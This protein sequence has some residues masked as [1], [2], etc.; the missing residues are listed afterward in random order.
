M[1]PNEFPLH[2]LK[3]KVNCSIIL[4][5]N[6]NPSE[7]LCNGTRLICRRFDRSVIDAEISVGEHKGK[8]VLLPRI[9]FVPVQN[10][11]DVFHFKRKQ[12]PV[13]LCFA[14]TINKA[15]GQTLSYVG[16]YFR[17]PVF[18]HGQLYVVLSR[19]KTGDSVRVLNC[20]DLINKGDCRLTKNIIFEEL[21]SLVNC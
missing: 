9:P 5:R 19:A 2:E 11:K 7:G 8:R 12:F 6:I 17:K 16:I 15:Q 4:L 18:S 3:L 13:R 1:V 20:E 21:L 10:V 14:M